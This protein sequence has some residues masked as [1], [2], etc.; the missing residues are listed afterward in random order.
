LSPTV[1][2]S[3][4]RIVRNFCIY[5]RRTQPNCY[6]P[7]PSLFPAKHQSV[8]PHIFSD[9]QASQLLVEIDRLR[10]SN[11]SPL[12]A[13]GFRTAFILFYTSGL[14]SGELIRLRIGDYN[15][16]EHTLLIRESKFHKSRLIPLSQDGWTAIERYLE[17]RR[18]RGFP[19]GVNSPIIWSKNGVGGQY[20]GTGL[21]T[22][23]QF[24]FEKTG[25]RCQNGD[26]PRIH[27]FRHTF[28]VRALL[29]W[30]Q[31][32]SDPQSKLPLLSIYMGH[33]SIVST[34]YY[35]QFIDELADAASARFAEKYGNLATLSI[36]RGV[37]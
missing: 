20:T 13:I 24:L 37:T 19:S 32:K 4:M 10:P 5:R 31:E 34:E 22:T 27:D 28:A 2:R 8:R 6:V 1:R 17:V 15:S 26:L 3:W 21:R 36:H 30:Y 14:R 23:F 29:R 33:V 16:K 35:L 25:I 11:N 18:S 12:R 7:D 9:P